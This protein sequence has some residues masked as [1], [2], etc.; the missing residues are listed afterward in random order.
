MFKLLYSSLVHFYLE[1][2][3]VIWRPTYQEDAKAIERVQRRA[4]R[5]EIKDLSYKTPPHTG[6]RACGKD[7]HS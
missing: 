7:F 5:R 4:N 2:G 1:Y 6:E 3:N